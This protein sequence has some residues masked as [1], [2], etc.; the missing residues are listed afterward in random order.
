MKIGVTGTRVGMT[1]KQ[2]V[3]FRRVLESLW[4]QNEDE[5]HHGDCI[6]ADA[7]AYAMA[8]GNFNIVC[9]PPRE[10]R[11]R[12][13]CGYGIIHP[14][15]EYTERNHDIVDACQVLIAALPD[16]EEAEQWMPPKGLSG[17]WATIRYAK[18][19]IPIFMVSPTGAYRVEW[20]DGSMTRGEDY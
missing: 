12:A 9:H 7:Q 20:P 19:K 6:G 11:W 16:A 18:G 3:T 5:L 15:K 2:Y 10:S 8:V 4:D 17:T 1:L 14:Q 13:F